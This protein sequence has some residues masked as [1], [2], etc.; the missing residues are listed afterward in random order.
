MNFDIEA[1]LNA[2]KIPLTMI[3]AFER[4][5]KKIDT[6]RAADRRNTIVFASYGEEGTA[7]Q[8]GEMS[9]FQPER[10][11]SAALV[12]VEFL[13]AVE[14][15]VKITPD[16]LWQYVM[17]A[18]PPRICGNCET[19]L[20]AGCGGLFKDDGAACEFGSAVQ[21]AFSKGDKT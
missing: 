17:R 3:E 10:E 11:L 21:A 8:R 18:P 4:I 7:L 13:R 9:S 6:A 1:L 5:L 19:A 20:P 15:G 14:R 16:E 12:A 2:E